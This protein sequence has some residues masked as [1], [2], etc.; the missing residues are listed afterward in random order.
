MTPEQRWAR[1]R[2]NLRSEICGLRT[3]IRI[4]QNRIIHSNHL[5]GEQIFKIERMEAELARL[6]ARGF[7]ARVFN[8]PV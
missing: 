1:E 5:M 7:W 2:G 4:L 3:E 6:K 8:L